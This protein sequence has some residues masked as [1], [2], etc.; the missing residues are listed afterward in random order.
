MQTAVSG[1]YKTKY[2]TGVNATR[3]MYTATGNKTDD[4]TMA[5]KFEFLITLKALI[6]QESVIDIQ[7]MTVESSAKITTTLPRNVTLSAKPLGGKYRIKCPNH[8]GMIY[9]T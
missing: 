7:S 3:T 8:K 4:V 6:S 1:F 5:T 2:D 9:Y